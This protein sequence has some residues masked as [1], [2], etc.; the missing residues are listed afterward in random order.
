MK[1]RNS[2]SAD[3]SGGFGGDSGERKLAD[4][5]GSAVVGSEASGSDAAAAGADGEEVEVVV[6]GNG[7]GAVL[8]F[9]A[10]DEGAAA[11]GERE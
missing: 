1:I 11:R 10:D 4:G 8:G 5:D 6:G 9:G 7:V 2:R 3:A